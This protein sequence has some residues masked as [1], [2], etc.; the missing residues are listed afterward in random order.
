MNLLNGLL[1]EELIFLKL[2]CNSKEQ[3]LGW[4]GNELVEKGYVMQGYEKALLEREA[5]Y[6]TGLVTTSCG[7][8]IPHAEPS[9]VIKERIAIGILED[10]VAFGNM[11]ALDEEVLVRVVFLLA[12][13]HSSQHLEVLQAV[14]SLFQNEAFMNNIQKAETKEDVLELFQSILL[15]KRG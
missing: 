8:A 3:L 2:K 13:K 4:L 9:Y 1:D 6:P 11:G 12:L 15:E 10:G 14:T 5:L 7:V